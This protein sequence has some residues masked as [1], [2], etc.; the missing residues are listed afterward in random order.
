MA[1]PSDLLFTPSHVWVLPDGDEI[2]VGITDFGQARLSDVVHV[3]LPEPD[4]HHYE[5]GEDLVVLESLRTATDLLAPVSG[6]VTDVNTL[7]MTKPEL[8]NEDPYG[9]GWLVR[10]RP[11]DMSDL[12]ELLDYHDY[13]S[14]LPPD[15]DEDE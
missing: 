7:L 10:M 12:D 5:H 14:R 9:E 4:D 1:E 15:H 11:A 6:V 2:V 3:E 13:E 8:V